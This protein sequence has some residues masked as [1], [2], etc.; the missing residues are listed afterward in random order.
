MM[1]KW[2]PCL[3]ILFLSNV[4]AFAQEEIT[5]PVEAP[6]QVE[7]PAP[8]ESP[9]TELRGPRISC[10]EPNFD[11]GSADSQ[12]VI[13]HT[14]VF[15]NTGD[16]T[17]EI[18]QARPACG[19]TVAELTEKNVP[20]GGESR[21]T[22]RLSLQGRTGHQSKAITIHSNDPENPQ[23]RVN[24]AGMVYQSVRVTPERLMFG[25]VAPGQETHQTVEVVGMSQT[26]FNI[27]RVEPTDASLS[28][29]VET[30]EE[31]KQYRI[32]LTLKGPQQPGPLSYLLR[33]FTDHPG[34]E[35]I[36]MPVSAH[37]VGDLIY[38]PSELVLPAHGDGNPLTRYIV[39]R[40]GSSGSFEVTKVTPPNP[41]IRV[42]IF[43]FGNQGYRVQ[44]ENIVPNI[45]LDGTSIRIETTTEFMS[46]INVPI[47][48][49]Q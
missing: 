32:N 44:L 23:Y 38:A 5:A 17:L 29:A 10:D 20:P 19:C 37:V 7:E 42:N 28:A 11:F 13:E 8:S 39:V 48:V 4:L 12:A 45:A 49:V 27:V 47:R 24:M 26:A 30:V 36:D 15:K 31:G 40:P 9:A 21:L 6:V 25:Q 34:R 2:M 46:V 16:T 3:L 33:I 18:T 35:V 14:F 1:K 41:D 43:P 22:A